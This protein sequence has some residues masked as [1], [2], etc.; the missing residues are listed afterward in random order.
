MVSHPNCQ[1]PYPLTAN[2]AIEFAREK[3]VAG[4]FLDDAVRGFCGEFRLHLTCAASFGV[5]G[6]LESGP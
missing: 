2:E 1:M 6:H 3:R 5:S 4:G